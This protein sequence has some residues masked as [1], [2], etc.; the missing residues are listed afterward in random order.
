LPTKD[1][2]SAPGPGSAASAETLL[3]AALEYTF[4]ASDPI[5][6]EVAFTA[7]RRH[8]RARASA[9]PRDDS[10]ALRGQG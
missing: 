10:A 2:A 9:A 3:D 6:V 4:P 8:E 5:A 7:R 1:T